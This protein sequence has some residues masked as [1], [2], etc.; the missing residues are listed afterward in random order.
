MFCI[1]DSLHIALS[2]NA[3]SCTSSPA[4]AITPTGN[5][6]QISDHLV[7]RGFDL[8]EPLRNNIRRL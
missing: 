5:P 1:A 2:G 4:C 7:L 3:G 8:Y 6:Q